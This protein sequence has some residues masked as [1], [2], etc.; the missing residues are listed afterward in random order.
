MRAPLSF[1]V[2]FVPP[3]S[4]SACNTRERPVI[5]Q[6]AAGTADVSDD[7]DNRCPRDADRIARQDVDIAAQIVG[8][9]PRQIDA[10]R[11]RLVPPNDRDL[12]R[13]RCAEPT[14]L[15]K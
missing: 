8:Q 10:N 3:A 12:A 14:S 6:Q 9:I 15:E 7:V 4:A 11:F 2:W 1:A 13:G 5:D